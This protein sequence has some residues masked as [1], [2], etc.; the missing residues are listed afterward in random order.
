MPR[1]PEKVGMHIEVFA[2]ELASVKELAEAQGFKI[3]ADY[4]R[5]LI[6]QNSIAAGKPITFTVNRGGNRR[7]KEE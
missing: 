4:V 7:Q 2:H 1:D 3:V 5:H 6:E